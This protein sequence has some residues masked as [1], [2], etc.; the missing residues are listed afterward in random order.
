[1]YLT[2]LNLQ[3]LDKNA[4]EFDII[5]KYVKNTHAQTHDLSL[6]IIDI[7]KVDR[8]GESE[9]FRADIGNVQLLWHGSPLS[10]YIGILSQGLRIAPPE[11]PVVRLLSHIVP[12]VLLLLLPLCLNFPDWL[13][14][15]K[16]D[17]HC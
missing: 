2:V 9:R 8:H 13:H 14:V 5:T 10:N 4:A 7:I 17:I 12:I 15:R 3:P 16:G 11:A 1:M 6:E